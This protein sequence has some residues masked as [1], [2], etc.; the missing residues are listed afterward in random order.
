MRPA[1]AA[2]RLHSVLASALRGAMLLLP[3]TVSLLPMSARAE[4]YAYVGNAD[5]ND[6]TVL[7]F[8]PSGEMSVVETVRFPNVEKPGGSTPLAVSPD[9]KMLYAGVRSEPFQ[10][11]AFALDPATGK[12]TFRGSAPLADSMAYVATDR[13]G[14]VLLSASY[15]GHKVALNPIGADGAVAA[16]K[17]V[18]P[19]GQNAHAILPS[20]DNRFAFATNLGSDQVLGFRLDPAA[21]TLTALEAPVAKTAE[22]NGPRHFVFAPDG[23]TVTLL[24]ELSA[25][26]MVYAY[27]AAT[28]AWKELQTASAL[29]PGFEGKPWAADLHLTPDGKLLYASERTSSTLAGFRVAA[30]G[31]LT[32]LGSTPTEKQPRGF[33]ID[34]TGRFLAAVGEASHSM[35]V[36]AIDAATGALKPQQTLPMGKKPNW[37]EFVTLP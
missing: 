8:A 3:L 1:V 33:A 22:K 4:T 2:P 11:L 14:K 27:D 35:T 28:G 9:K 29:P 31:R 13:T 16:P 7:K 5:S 19:T 20:P 23:K 12:L 15:G 37:V 26:V 21:G 18:V 17:Q 32:P 30:D 6:I 36:Y 10:V 24:N 34:P 25:A